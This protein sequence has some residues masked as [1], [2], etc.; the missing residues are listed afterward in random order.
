M[1]IPVYV[2]Q[3][4]SDENTIFLI[5]FHPLNLSNPLVSH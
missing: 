2:H 5:L 1:K 4:I 3:I